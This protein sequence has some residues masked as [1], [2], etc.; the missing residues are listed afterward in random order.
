MVKGLNFSGEKN[1]QTSNGERKVKVLTE[2]LGSKRLL[3]LVSH[4]L[5]SWAEQNSPVCL[6]PI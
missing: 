1:K 3:C 4:G 5:Q 2:A 6:I